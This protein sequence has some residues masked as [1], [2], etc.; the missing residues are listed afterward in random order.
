MKD[1][2]RDV[3]SDLPVD[4]T[5]KTTTQKRSR[6]L[7]PL[8]PLDDNMLLD[9]NDMSDKSLVDSIKLSRPI[10]PL[11]RP[12]HSLLET[13]SLPNGALLFGNP[14]HT[15]NHVTTKTIDEEDDWSNQS[16]GDDDAFEPMIL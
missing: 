16:P 3:Y 8:T 13:R 12:R 9:D 10:K 4:N 15:S 6:S 11:R 5:N 7:S 1:T 2:L 14:D